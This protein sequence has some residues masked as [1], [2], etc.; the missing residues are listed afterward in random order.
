[1]WWR[2]REIPDWLTFTFSFASELE[3]LKRTI[4]L[5]SYKLLTDLYVAQA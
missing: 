5:F 2:N 1:M 3:A 4:R